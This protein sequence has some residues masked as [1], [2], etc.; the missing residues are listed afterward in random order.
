ML[1]TSVYINT[2]FIVVACNESSGFCY[3]I[4]YSMGNRVVKSCWNNFQDRGIENEGE[5]EKGY[6]SSD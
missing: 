4:K 6:Q 5:E 3:L 1:Y 2:K